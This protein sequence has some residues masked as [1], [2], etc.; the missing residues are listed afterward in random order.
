MPSFFFV[1][2]SIIF[3]REWK[4]VIFRLLI[5]CFYVIQNSRQAPPAV[6]Q[7]SFAYDDERLL[8]KQA[9]LRRCLTLWGNNTTTSSFFVFRWLSIF[10]ITN[11]C[12]LDTSLCLNPAGQHTLCKSAF[13]PICRC[14]LWPST[15]A[16]LT[17]FY[18]Y[19]KNPFKPLCPGHRLVLLCPCFFLP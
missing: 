9:Y 14:P 18:V 15:T 8:F 2:Q 1:Y 19:P 3:L 17:G 11:E 10:W 16:L 6:V 5:N 13:L 4:S 7:T 12:S